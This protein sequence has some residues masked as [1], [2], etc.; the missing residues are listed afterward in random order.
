[1][2]QQQRTALRDPAEQRWGWQRERARGGGGRWC[3]G[4]CRLKLLWCLRATRRF[5]SQWKIPALRSP[6]IQPSWGHQLI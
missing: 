4:S 3:P 2:P 1:M 6:V 5:K